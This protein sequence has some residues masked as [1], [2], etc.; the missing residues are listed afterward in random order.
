MKRT[1]KMAE[2]F[3]VLDKNATHTIQITTKEFNQLISE[4]GGSPRVIPRDEAL[5]EEYQ[6]YLCSSGD[7]PPVS[8]DV[9]EERY[10]YCACVFDNPDP[11]NRPAEMVM[12]D[13]LGVKSLSVCYAKDYW[14]RNMNDTLELRYN[15]G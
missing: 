5:E 7:K 1:K 14:G 8:K 6:T 10:F 13:L 15:A 2:Q 9:Y 3:K 12:G 11:E 4:L